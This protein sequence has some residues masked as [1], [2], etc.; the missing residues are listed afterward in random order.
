MSWGKMSTIFTQ[1]VAKC[2]GEFCPLGQ[3]MS[4]GKMS[5]SRIVIVKHFI[6]AILTSKQWWVTITIN[7]EKFSWPRDLTLV[8]IDAEAG[9][10]YMGFPPLGNAEMRHHD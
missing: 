4:W 9:S 6:L 1:V 2:L 3:K 8:A 5:P 7:R 10:A